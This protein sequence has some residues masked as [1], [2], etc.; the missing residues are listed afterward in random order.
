MFRSLLACPE[1]KSAGEWVTTADRDAEALLTPQLAAVIPGSVVVGEE[2]AAADPH[3]PHR[4]ADSGYVW[5]LDPLD[6]TANFAA[7]V[8]PFAMMVAL[9]HNGD[10]VA[11]WILDPLTGRLAVA[12]RG[13]G[14][15]VDGRR[16]RTSETTGA[17]S[18]LRGAVLRRFLPDD[19]RSHIET[20]H[21]HF[22]EISNGSG[23]A[24]YD[25]PGIIGGDS[26]FTLYWR[27]HPWDH[28]PGVLIVL[29]AGGSAARPDGSP[30]RAPELGRSGLLVA[31]N[32]DTWSRTRD[33][34]VPEAHR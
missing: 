9:L 11:A 24:G 18:E 2:A 4:L 19:L 23:C 20:M 26:D 29:E 21:S 3:V 12:E 10:T 17:I 25:Y 32:P 27:T 15:W 28:A 34:L 5:L 14:T 33:N 8:A 13:G 30:Y 7:G 6:G 1:E 16:V 31:A 22:S